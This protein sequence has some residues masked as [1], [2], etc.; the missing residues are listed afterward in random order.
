MSRPRPSRLFPRSL[1][2]VV[3][4]ATK[5]LVRQRGKFYTALVRDWTVIVGA[6]RAAYLSPLKIQFIRQGEEETATLHLAVSA[7]RAP[8]AAYMQEQLLEQL[9]RYFG[10]KAIAR[11]V[12]HPTHAMVSEET[13]VTAETAGAQP[14]LTLPASIPREFH[15]IF[16]R[17]QRHLNNK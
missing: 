14:P 12:L 10:Y 7:E 17:I 3:K 13:A 4:E 2:D 9:A 5:P 8:E 1:A 15:A 11:L 16:E 6:Q